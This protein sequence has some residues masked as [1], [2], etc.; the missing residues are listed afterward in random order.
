MGSGEAD[1]RPTIGAEGRGVLL[2]CTALFIVPTPL[3][4]QATDA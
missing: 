2:E 3:G 4:G 1:R